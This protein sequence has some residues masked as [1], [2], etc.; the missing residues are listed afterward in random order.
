MSSWP[1]ARVDQGLRS[2]LHGTTSA[3]PGSSGSEFPKACFGATLPYFWPKWS[4]R[5]M[6]C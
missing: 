6:F 5:V 2:A 1:A 3:G 4:Y